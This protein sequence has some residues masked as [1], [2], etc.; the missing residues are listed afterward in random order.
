MFEPEHKSHWYLIIALGI[1]VIIGWSIY[2]QYKPLIIKASC[3]EIA[4]KSS[5]LIYKNIDSFEP[6]Y[7]YENINK[8]CI[9]DSG[10]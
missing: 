3:S 7:S 10:I 5:D 4:A 9:K 6:V 2:S 1:A 8:K